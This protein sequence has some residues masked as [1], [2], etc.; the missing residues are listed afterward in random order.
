MKK[1]LYV[2]CCLCL[3]AAC[4]RTESQQKIDVDLDETEAEI[5]YSGFAESVSMSP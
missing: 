3:W 4:Q 2:V 1:Y 5:A